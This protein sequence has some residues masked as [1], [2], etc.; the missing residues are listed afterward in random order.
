MLLKKPGHD[1]V[2]HT[3]DILHKLLQRLENEDVPKQ[4]DQFFELAL[5]DIRI[6]FREYCTGNSENKWDG[7]ITERR[8]I[9]NLIGRAQKFVLR[10][11]IKEDT[12]SIMEKAIDLIIVSAG[13]EKLPEQKRLARFLSFIVEDLKKYQVIRNAQQHTA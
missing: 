10:T 3:I 7:F 4:N 1:P 11:Y 12:F 6:L 13:N 8:E 9:M 5:E 2:E